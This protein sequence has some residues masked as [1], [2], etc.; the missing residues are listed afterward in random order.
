M[1]TLAFLVCVVAS[2][3]ARAE[4][5]AP[6]MSRALLH[7][8]VLIEFERTNGETGLGTGFFYFFD[9][10][11]RTSTIPVIVTCCHVVSKASVGR[12]HFALGETNSFKR[13]QDDFPLGFQNFE[14][15][16]IRHPDTN[17]DLAVMPIAPVMRALE[18]AGK[19]L[20]TMPI[21]NREIPTK[22]MLFDL[23]VFREVKFIGYPQ[24]IWDQK[25]NLPIVRRGMTATDPVI[26]YNG[27]PEFLID[28]AVFPGSSG[29][30][31]FV[32]EENGS[33]A[34]VTSGPNKGSMTFAGPRLQF[35]GILYAVEEYTSEG[36][37]DVVTIPTS[38][39]IKV[40]SRI[41][42]NLGLVIKADRL[43]D[44]QS[45]FE[46][47]EKREDQMAKQGMTNPPTTN[48]PVSNK[49]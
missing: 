2:F 37:V 40:N 44:F 1:R 10:P 36:K 45:I 46:E 19:L 22:D 3:L 48:V 49:H 42:A 8:T 24:G 31:V 17:I 25:N 32:A 27:R 23:G 26:D 43:N 39:D 4:E 7:S 35:L 14:S 9:D 30:P 47:I 12:I 20:D 11:S 28:A 38:F 15:L 21:R 5:P 34:R 29:S 33:F 18:S 13:T 6:L 16:W 41:P